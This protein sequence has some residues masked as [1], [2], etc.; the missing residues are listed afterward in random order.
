MATKGAWDSVNKSETSE[1]AINGVFD[2]NHIA[3]AEMVINDINNQ[4]IMD[5]EKSGLP[6]QRFRMTKK[7]SE[8]FK[9][10]FWEELTYG[11]GAMVPIVAEF[12][13]VSA[14]TRGLGSAEYL[15]TKFAKP[16][17]RWG[18]PATKGARYSKTFLTTEKLA[19]KAAAR[20]KS[21]YKT[22]AK[23]AINKYKKHYNLSKVEGGIVNQSKWAAMMAAKEELNVQLVNTIFDQEFP[24]GMGASFWMGGHLAHTA[25]KSWRFGPKNPKLAALNPLLEK[26]VLGGV[27]FAAASEVALPFEGLVADMMDNKSWRR[28]V[29]E[30][31]ESFGG[32]GNRMLHNVLLGGGLGVQHHFGK[33]G[34]DFKFS[35]AAKEKFKTE[36]AKDIIRWNKKYLE[37]GVKGDI[38]AMQKIDNDIQKAKELYTEADRQIRMNSRV[39]EYL[40]LPDRKIALEKNL[41]QYNTEYKKENGDNSFT[42]K[43]VKPT[44]NNRKGIKKGN[45]HQTFYL[46]QLIIL[47]Q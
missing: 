40:N 14:M 47:V 24:P 12:A 43:I 18:V 6:P 17:V 46:N 42:F 44:K 3:N 41:K 37:S 25:M 5:A 31:Y 9:Q 11:G 36:R 16:I 32:V 8:N 39:S 34:L 29:E 19:E 28:H 45:R 26:H 13:F 2:D 21:L 1:K 20:Y 4:A 15:A 22:D 10:S 30:N 33:K 23:A 35:I 38:E 27:G 7:E